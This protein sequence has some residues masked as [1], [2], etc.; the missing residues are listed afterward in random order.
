MPAPSNEGAGYG[1]MLSSYIESVEQ[2]ALD[3]C[4][5]GHDVGS[6]PRA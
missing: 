2:I 1:V 6:N 3:A 4:L 5:R